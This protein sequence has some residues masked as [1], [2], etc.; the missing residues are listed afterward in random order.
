MA[1]I[2]GL[3]LLVLLVQ[4]VPLAFWLRQVETDRLTT[5]LERD[6]FV[7]AGRSE[8]LLETP[9]AEAVETLAAL[10]R[11]YR[12]AGGARVV[13][14]DAD[15][16]AVVTSD[17]DQASLGTSYASRPEIQSALDGSIATGQRYSATLG[18]ELTYVAVPV[19]SGEEILGAVRLTYPEQVIT[20]AVTRRLGV[21]GIVALTAAL[22]AGVVGVVFSSTVTRRLRL[23]ESVT[24]VLANGDLGARADDRSGAPEIRALSRSF[25]TMADRLEAMVDQQR[26]F[27]GDASHQLRT[28]LTALRLRLEAARELAST[29]P[30]AAAERIAAAEAEADRLLTIVEGL[31]RLARIESGDAPRVTED[32]A[33]IARERVEHWQ[34]LAHELGV[35]LRYSGPHR[36]RAVALE[37]AVEQVIDNYI[38]N[39]LGVSPAGSMIDVAV[40]S[41]VDYVTL[42]VSDQGPGL[43]AEQRDHAF[44]RFWQADSGR[45]GSGLGLA[46]VR[47][48][49]DA[50][51]GSVHVEARA[52]GGLS[53][54]ARFVRAPESSS[55][56]DAA[57]G[58]ARSDSLN[59]D[60]LTP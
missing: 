31:L 26:A 58:T 43:T 35:D 10:A 32:V 59:G 13:I 15:G 41:E 53:A 27:A 55:P 8:E 29:D 40:T 34:A 38:D 22:L 33:A 24:Q 7:L 25:N 19:L 50:G 37:H 9:S 46:I 30:D 12:D 48:L 28:P 18:E 5:A 11:E 20:D 54:V 39:A 3:T 57:S 49:V 36:A 44:D 16:T 56:R 21:L 6:A 17:D 23:L 60:T 47:G 52:G 51:G 2:M 42:T 45:G 4:D 14:V 1:A